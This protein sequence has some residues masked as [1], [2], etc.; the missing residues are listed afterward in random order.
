M[1]DVVYL[2]MINKSRKLKSTSRNIILIHDHDDTTK[3]FNLLIE[4]LL[5]KGIKFI[6]PK[7]K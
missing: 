7:L 2:R 3:Y 5:K 4:T 1:Q 6:K